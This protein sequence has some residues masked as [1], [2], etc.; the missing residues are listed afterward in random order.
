MG[1]GKGKTKRTRATETAQGSGKLEPLQG[2]EERWS[3]RWE[4]EQVYRF[5]RETTRE[6]VFSIDTPPPTVSGD[7]HVGHLFSYT[8]TDLIARFQ[9]MRGKNVFYPMGW[10]DNGLATER[11]VQYYFNVNC[12]PGLAYEG[13]TEIDEIAGSAGQRS[14]LPPQTISRRG[15]IELCEL[16][17]AEDEKRFEALWR[18]LGLSADWS[19]TYTTIGRQAR[20]VSQ[21]SFLKLLEEGAVYTEEAPTSWDVG[22]RTAVAQAEI[23]ERERHPRS[24]AQSCL[25]VRRRRRGRRSR[26]DKARNDSCLRCPGREPRR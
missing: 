6:K 9:R 25:P 3:E 24:V 17:A 15:F 2:L 13:K 4:E 20:E 1:A 7:L 23:E 26:D 10:D 11:R 14:K 18:K 21:A 22:F 19:L 12:D 16:L 8:H 5:D